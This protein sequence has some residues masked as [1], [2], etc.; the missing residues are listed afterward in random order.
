MG[1]DMYLQRKPRKDEDVDA[2]D[3]GYWRKANAIHA[4]F[5]RDLEDGEDNMRRVYLKKKDLM[6]LKERC[7]KVIAG[8]PDD[9]Q[10]WLPTKGGFFWGSQD[11]DEY[12]LKDIQDTLDIVSEVLNDWKQ[13]DRVYYYAWY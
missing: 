3:L 12:Y 8:G 7:M 9:A 6:D 11:Y 1:L 13:N 5:T 10:V 2:V 4:Y